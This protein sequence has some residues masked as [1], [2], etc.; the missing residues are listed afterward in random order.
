MLTPEQLYPLVVEWLHALGGPRHMTALN[1][2]AALVTALLLSQ[3]L[4]PS[5]LMRTLPSPRPVPARQRYRR[6]ARSL[7]RLG[8]AAARLTPRL[9]RAALTLV[10]ADPERSP[11]AG[12]THLALDSVRCGGWEIFTLGVVWHGRVLPVGWRVLP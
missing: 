9:V 7:D 3:S 5:A 1:S 6:V 12:Q 11:T 8:L 10:P 4:R 2:L